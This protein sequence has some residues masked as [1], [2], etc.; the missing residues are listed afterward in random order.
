[1]IS[2]SF[3]W[4]PDSGR[5]SRSSCAAIWATVAFVSV[6]GGCGTRGPERFHVMGT[7]TFRGQPIPSGSIRFDPDI[8]RGNSGPVGMAPISDGKYA[9]E[10]A[11]ARGVVKGPAVVW[12]SGYPPADSRKEVQPPLFPDY[13]TTVDIK[14]SG[15][16]R[17]TLDFT[18]PDKRPRK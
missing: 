17:L 12:I 4:H 8:S 11:G 3:W 18:V 16:G 7:V 6:A 1:M 14:P 2:L 5:R 15:S 9:T 13:S 10:E